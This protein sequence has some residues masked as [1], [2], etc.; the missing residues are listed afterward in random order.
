MDRF[1][2]TIPSL[3]YY[4]MTLNTRWEAPELHE[5]SLQ[6]G[7][8]G[9]T[10]SFDEMTAGFASDIYAFASVCV[11]VCA[12][13]LHSN[14]QLEYNFACKQV[15]SGENPHFE[16]ITENSRVTERR[17]RV[18]VRIINAVL[19]GKRPIRPASISDPLWSIVERCWS[20]L[21]AARPD[22][23]TL[24]TMLDSICLSS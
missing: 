19:A 21:P 11:E 18:A 23:Q 15:Y 16:G 9:L 12:A 13:T 22:A 2:G 20:Q 24:L 7:T 8:Q 1:L 17:R 5:F 4:T 3:E 6:P 14:L 10:E